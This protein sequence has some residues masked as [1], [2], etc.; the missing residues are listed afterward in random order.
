MESG[1]IEGSIVS[2][3]ASGNLVSDITPERLDGVPTDDQISI[4]C[5]EHVTMGIFAP[6][7]DQP[8]TTLIA[9]IGQS[10]NLELCIVGDSAKVM[11]GVT[12][13]E[14]VLVQW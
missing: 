13:G 9:L 4:T 14:R 3:D 10:G 2:I 1:R 12:V 7:H 5:D 11:L 8:E 6:G